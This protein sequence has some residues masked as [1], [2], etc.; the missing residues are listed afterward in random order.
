MDNAE[1]ATT[2]PQKKAR[3]FFLRD[4]NMFGCAESTYI[5]LK[6]LYGLPNPTHSAAAM[7]LN[8]GIAYSGSTCGAITGAAMAV[9][10][11]AESRLNNHKTAKTVARRIIMRILAAFRDKYVSEKCIDLIELDISKQEDHDAFIERGVW[12]TTCMGQIEYVVGEL[13]R[14]A[15][16]DVWNEW[17]ASVM[18]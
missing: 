18:Q 17:V 9:G 14:L 3:E 15:D 11:L 1:S 8:G 16:E 7:A 2:E 5:T 12:K 10:E 13:H 4:D 6:T